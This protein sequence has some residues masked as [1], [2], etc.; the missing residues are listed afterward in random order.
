MKAFDII[1]DRVTF[2]P[3]FLAV[4]EFKAIWDRD[5]SKSKNKAMKELSFIVFLCDNTT[6]N[7]YMGYSEDIREDILK[8]DFIGD[9]KWEPD[10]LVLRAIKKLDSLF[11]TPSARLLKGALVAADQLAN[12]FKN[13]DFTETD[14]QGKQKYSARELS[15][16]LSSVGNI[17]KSLK[18]LEKQVRQEQLDDGVAR[19]GSEIGMFELPTEDKDE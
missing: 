11:E 17:I 6:I 16:N 15:S 9:S 19:G 1:G 10:E 12:W 14:N 13:I 4:P 18:Q 8:E 7:P 5:K 2:K 3:E